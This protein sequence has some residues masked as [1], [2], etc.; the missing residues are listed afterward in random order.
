MTAIE[1]NQYAVRILERVWFYK[2][3]N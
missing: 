1:S 3:S 2:T